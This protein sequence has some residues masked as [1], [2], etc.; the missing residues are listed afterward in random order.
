MN[1]FKKTNGKAE[2][3]AT[4]TDEGRRSFL[5]KL[6]LGGLIAGLAGFALQ[7]FRSL[8]PNVLYEPPRRFR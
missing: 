8:I 3:A 4:G 7:S 1:F 2:R 6:G 5:Q